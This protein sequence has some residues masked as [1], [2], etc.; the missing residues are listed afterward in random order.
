MNLQEQIEYMKKEIVE[1]R[2]LYYL[3]DD[4]DLS[5]AILESLLKLQTLTNES[6]D[7]R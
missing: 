3:K 7:K 5:K 2:D 4:Y 6:E 1:Y